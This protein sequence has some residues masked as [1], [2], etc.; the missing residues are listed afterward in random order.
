M[1]GLKFYNK[2]K[3]KERGKKTKKDLDIV[4]SIV[5]IRLRPFFFFSK[6]KKSLFLGIRGPSREG[7]FRDV[8]NNKASL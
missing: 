6:N 2:K 1:S 5:P 3:K 4:T 8:I 7:P